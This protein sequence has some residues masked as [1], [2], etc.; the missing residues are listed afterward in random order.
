[1]TPFENDVLEKIASIV[2]ACNKLICYFFG[3]NDDD[4]KKF[5]ETS[6]YFFERATCKR[7]GR[8]NDR[9]IRK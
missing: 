7:C 9:E 2:D 5:S 6:L 4:F 3:H 8:Y 1:M